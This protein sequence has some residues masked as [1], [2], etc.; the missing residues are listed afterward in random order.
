MICGS[1]D[2]CE[3]GIGRCVVISEREGEEMCDVIALADRDLG[4]S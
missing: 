1:A 4:Y 2:G 3:D